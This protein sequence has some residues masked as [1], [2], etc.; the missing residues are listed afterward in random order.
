MFIL[1]FLILVALFFV[2]GKSADF[3]IE[4]IKAIGAKT[5][6]KTI[7]IGFLLGFL[8]SMPELFIGVNAMIKD[9]GAISFGNLVG[10]IIVLLGFIMGLN[11]VLRREVEMV[12]GLKFPFLILLG[13]FLTLPLLLVLDGKI[14]FLDGLLLIICYV[15]LIIY[16]LSKRVQGVREKVREQKINVRKAVI[17][18]VLG[19]AGIIILSRFII[20]IT[21]LLLGGLNIGKLMLGIIVFSIGTNLPEIVV[22][23]ES[24]RKQ[25]KNIALG[26]LLGSAMANI[27]I[28]GAL[29]LIKP[30]YA[31]MSLNFYVFAITFVLIIV[32]F[33]FFSYTKRKLSL[34]EG[35][36]LIGIYLFF[37]I[38]E[39][40]LT[41]IKL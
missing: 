25:V 23:F 5:R 29:S 19:M 17:F 34:W 39:F 32:A 40:L 2:L 12:D 31:T 36:V 7:Y 18:A 4:G 20:E 13:V 26:N 41:G 30:F 8:T 16:W 35:A 38:F 21:L 14:G 9:V 1:Y 24:W 22:V 33:L 3:L 11:V 37:I 27:F 28:I 10:G 6:I 15:G